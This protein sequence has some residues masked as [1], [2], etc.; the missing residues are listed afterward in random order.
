MADAVKSA[1]FAFVSS[2]GNPYVAA[3]AFFM[4][5]LPMVL[6]EIFGSSD[7]EPQ[8]TR[9]FV[10]RSAQ[11]PRQVIYGATRVKDPVLAYFETTNGNSKLH[12]IYMFAGHEVEA[13]DRFWIGDEELGARNADGTVIEGRFSGFVRLRV[14][15]GAD[16]QEADAKAIAELTDWTETDRLQGIAYVYA[17]FT[18]SAELFRRAPPDLSAMIRGRKVLNRATGVETWTDNAHACN[19]DYLLNERFG[20]AADPE[21]ING[22]LALIDETV[23]DVM[24]GTVYQS[25]TYTVDEANSE[26][27]LEKPGFRTGDRI[28]F[29]AQPPAPLIAGEPYFWIKTGDDKGKVATDLAA[30]RAHDFIAF[31]D[32]GAAF[33]RVNREAQ[34]R[35][36]CNGS[37]LTSEGRLDVLERLGASMASTPMLNAS[38][39][40]LRAGDDQAAVGHLDETML[41]GDIE[42]EPRRAFR[43]LINAVGGTYRNADELWQETDFP[44]Q[45]S[46]VF[47]A[48]DGGYRL[49][50]DLG[51]KFTDETER[52]QRLA[53]IQ[54][55]QSRQQVRLTWPGNLSCIQFE[56]GDLVTVTV[57]QLGFEAK[58]FWVY[59]DTFGENGASYT[60]RLVEAADGL[61]DIDLDELEAAD[62]APNSALQVPGYLAPPGG[63]A[64]ATRPVATSAADQVYMIDIYGTASPDA[65]ATTYQAALFA[66]GDTKFVNPLGMASAAAD[67]AEAFP[68]RIVLG[69]VDPSSEFVLRL[70]AITR[71]G[72][73]SAWVASDTFIAADEV[74][75]GG[76]AAPALPTDLLNTGEL[77]GL[78]E[79]WN[80]SGALSTTTG[81]GSGVEGTAT[82]NPGAD[83]TAAT[84]SFDITNGGAGFTSAPTVIITGADG[85]DDETGQTGSATGIIGNPTHAHLT[86]T[87]SVDADL[88][89]IDV[90]RT[91]TNDSAT[92]IKRAEALAGVQAASVAL[93]VSAGSDE[94][95]FLKAVDQSGNQSAFSAA[96]TVTR[97]A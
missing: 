82:H 20:F 51:L 90:Y 65:A 66:A 85:Q 63:V 86:W 33:Y 71:L 32:A 52:A 15:L 68:F 5:V 76:G 88:A 28:S 55:A 61:F 26:L 2:G 44:E 64:F 29:E 93:T 39:Y 96:I 74:G 11:A 34:P 1:A 81:G 75:G 48:Q 50:R 92:A 83:D 60:L 41:A 91:T 13:F 43:E 94:F 42:I 36:T 7:K 35:Y 95:F 38:G 77:T 4:A 97:D 69:P 40:R 23:G 18:G 25:F 53:R 12:C 17:T 24:V 46:D 72:I 59:H 6:D 8:Q 57:A 73:K 70:R 87:D 19:L 10:I 9:E 84:Y 78:V 27:T 89:R 67:P 49:K 54:L 22:D 21:L 62:P 56:R 3:F 31:T 79:P 58:K 14:H 30:A 16:D 37:F 47:K 80:G 45:A